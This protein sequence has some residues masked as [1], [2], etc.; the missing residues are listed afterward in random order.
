MFWDYTRLRRS[1][2]ICLSDNGPFVCQDITLGELSIP[3]LAFI[4][5]N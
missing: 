5:A 3:L 2:F 4:L 1:I